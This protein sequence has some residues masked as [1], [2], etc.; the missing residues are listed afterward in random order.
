MSEGAE[1]P[2]K[3]FVA[4]VQALLGPRLE[5]VYAYGSEFGRG[6]KAPDANLLVLVKAID[7]AL[8]EDARTLAVAAR[9]ARISMR[10][11]TANDVLRSTDVFPVFVLE[12]SDTKV[13]LAGTDVLSNLAVEKADL[14]LRVEQALRVL[15]RDLLRA[16][17][18]SADDRALA[19]ELRRSVKKAVYLLRAL[20]LVCN[21]E[22]GSTPSAETTI[23]AVVGALLPEHREVLH[24]MR[25]F[26][27]FEDALEHDDLVLLYCESLA[28]LSALVDKVDR[29]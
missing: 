23:D 25:R 2:V 19:V 22:L 13:L 15:R 11:E 3:G 14:R 10:L 12:L 1:S 7:R 4:Q 29:L 6:A 27:T 24:R 17:V 18:E 8:L 16:Y 9:E 21:V 28:S 26:A 5:A 20:A